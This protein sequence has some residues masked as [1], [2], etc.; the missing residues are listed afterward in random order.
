MKFAHYQTNDAL[1]EYTLVTQSELST[2]VLHSCN[3]KL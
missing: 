1:R 3:G 2:E